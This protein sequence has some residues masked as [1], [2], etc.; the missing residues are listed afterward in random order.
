MINQNF[1]PGHYLFLGVIFVAGSI[2]IWHIGGPQPV[3]QKGFDASFSCKSDRLLAGAVSQSLLS[4]PE[5]CTV[6]LVTVEDKDAELQFA[7]NGRIDY[8][9]SIRT[10]SGDRERFMLA[11]SR[12]RSRSAFSSVV[13]GQPYYALIFRQQ[14]ASIAISGQVMQTSDNPDVA[15]R[16]N[17]MRWI[18]TFVF[19]ALAAYSFYCFGRLYAT[20]WLPKA[21]GAD[22]TYPD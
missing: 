5:P 16:G 7:H 13:V 6:E 3:D 15:A 2:W 11:E 22:L 19:L 14:V 18:G 4:L 1:S 21:S 20:T 17:T 9:L 8:W 10:A 12:P